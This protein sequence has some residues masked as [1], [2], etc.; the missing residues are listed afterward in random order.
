MPLAD[1]DTDHVAPPIPPG[2]SEEARYGFELSAH[3]TRV[4]ARVFERGLATL[5][6]EANQL[7]RHQELKRL[8]GGVKR[9][10]ADDSAR[11]AGLI[12]KLIRWV[13]SMPTVKQAVANTIV[14]LLG[15]V[16]LAATVYAAT[17]WGIAGTGAGS[18]T[19]ITAPISPDLP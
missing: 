8:L 13:D 10:A 11:A 1:T 17:H 2:L 18:P 6:T 7:G 16:T 19:V 12:D 5:P 9:T 3:N 4:L 15:I 14:G